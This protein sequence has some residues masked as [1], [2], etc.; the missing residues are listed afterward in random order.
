MRYS[1]SFLLFSLSFGELMSFSTLFFVFLCISRLQIPFCPPHLIFLFSFA[2]LFHPLFTLNSN[3]SHSPPSYQSTCSHLADHHYCG[4]NSS[5]KNPDS[6]PCGGPEIGA[7]SLP[8][9]LFPDPVD[10]MFLNV[11]HSPAYDGSDDVRNL[12]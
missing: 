10:N 4:E 12:G 7:D 3:F 9:T 5:Q 1:H 6:L 2:R 11:R 8:S